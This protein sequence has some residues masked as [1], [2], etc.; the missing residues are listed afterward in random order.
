MR[1]GIK[2]VNSR[3]VER[4]R[5]TN[6]PM[7]F[8]SFF[9]KK[10]GEITSV[11]SG[12]AGDQRLF[13]DQSCTC[14]APSRDGRFYQLLSNQYIILLSTLRR[15]DHDSCQH[16]ALGAEIRSAIPFASERHHLLELRS[17]AKRRFFAGA[18]DLNEF[19]I[20]RRDQIE[21]DRDPLCLPSNLDRQS[22]DHPGFQR[23][24]RRPVF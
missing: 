13:H 15:T 21:I 10:I 16:R 1:I 20:L 3:S 6:D 23:S 12:D 8:I 19:P 14:S 11:L 9:K 5:A 22:P 4:A 18:L 17:C 24:P 7:N 2:M